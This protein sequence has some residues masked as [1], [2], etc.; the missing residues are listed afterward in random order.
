MTV[1]IEYALI[2]NFLIDGGLLLLSLLLLKREISLLK[3]ALAALLGAGFAVLYPL[4]TL[5][6]LVS[7]TLKFAVGVL[8]CLIASKR[9]K[10][11]SRYAMNVLSF[12]VCSFLFAGFLFA[13]GDLFEGEIVKRIPVGGLFGGGVIF[14]FFLH[15]FIKKLYFMRKINAFLYNCELISGKN[16]LKL[17]GF[18]DSGNQ[19]SYGGRPVCFLSAKRVLDLIEVGQGCDEMQILTVGGEKTIKIF[20]IDK[21]L[22]YSP[23]RLNIIEKVIEKV[24]ISPSGNLENGEYELLLNGAL[25]S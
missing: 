14:A 6:D 5:P 25:F 19:A 7:Y 8:L 2:E 4:V 23:N 21:L 20:Q 16:Q 15:K 17:K 24:Y 18:L 1:Y 22:I 9:E 13:V 12:F 3:I 11:G 10:K